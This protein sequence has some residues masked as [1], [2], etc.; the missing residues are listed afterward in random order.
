MAEG[1]ATGVSLHAATG[2]PVAVA[3]DAGNLKEAAL[4]IRKKLPNAAI[5]ICADNDHNRPDGKNIGLIKAKEAAAE[6]GCKVV[7]ADFLPDEKKR[8]LTD[9]NDL[10]KSRGLQAVKEQVDKGIF[11]AKETA[12]NVQAQEVER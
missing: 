6:V 4:A 11:A 12:K 7:V 1:Y 2:L 9:F 8:G 5:T 3:F 10:H